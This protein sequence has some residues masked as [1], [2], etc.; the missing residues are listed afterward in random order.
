MACT[1][2]PTALREA[3]RAG[4]RVSRAVDRDGFRRGGLQE[5]V[6]ELVV[7]FEP[8]GGDNKLVATGTGPTQ[9]DF[10]RLVQRLP[11]ISSLALHRPTFDSFT[12][13]SL[14]T[15]ADASSL[16]KITSIGFHLND[17]PALLL[18][19]LS[20]TR[21]VTTL[22]IGDNTDDRVL[23][24]FPID[25]IKVNLH[26]LRSL[27]LWG[28]TLPLQLASLNLLNPASLAQVS[29]LHYLEDRRDPA[30]PSTS[31]LFDI[32]GPSLRSLHW[33]SDLDDITDVLRSCTQLD[34]L[35]VAYANRPN[36]SDWIRVVPGT[37]R[38]IEFD[39][40]REART[41]LT[42]AERE[43]AW[44]VGLKEVRVSSMKRWNEVTVDAEGNELDAWDEWL[45]FAHMKEMCSKAGREFV[46][47]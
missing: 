42:T 2:T 32:I 47:A 10:V 21:S 5:L 6:K 43:E 38:S 16:S 27:T 17:S 25:T 45:P 19:I 7:V 40:H 35:H 26:H 29:T 9:A 22:S 20:R 33:G 15:L 37:V 28:G 3:G 39:D 23:N 30:P 24:P 18:P 1:R 8:C 34:T 31:N 12:P 46:G 14:Q 13:E 44:P 41:E 11:R 36:S 4:W